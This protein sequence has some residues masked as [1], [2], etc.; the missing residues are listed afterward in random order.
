MEGDR[1]DLF[2]PGQASHVLPFSEFEAIYPGG[3][4]PCRPKEKQLAD[5]D[6]LGAASAKFGFRWFIPELLKHRRIFRDVLLASF[7][8]QLMAND[9]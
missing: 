5:P 8:I 2:E 3:V 7:A 6:A 1:V 4:L 9:A